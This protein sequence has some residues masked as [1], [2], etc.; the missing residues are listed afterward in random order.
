MPLATGSRVASYAANVPSLNASRNIF[1]RSGWNAMT[2]IGLEEALGS[3]NW[4][5][6]FRTRFWTYIPVGFSDAVMARCDVQ[7]RLRAVGG[8]G[9]SLSGSMRDEFLRE[10]IWT[11]FWRVVVK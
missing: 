2:S 9:S 1:A 7:E 10:Y 11:A 4:G 5:P 6:V 3:S 8:E